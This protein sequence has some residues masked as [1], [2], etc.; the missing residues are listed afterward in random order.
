M[1]TSR[2]APEGDRCLLAAQRKV[3]ELQFD[4]DMLQVLLEKRRASVAEP[5]S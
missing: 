2:S 3:G 1:L 5:S 4:V